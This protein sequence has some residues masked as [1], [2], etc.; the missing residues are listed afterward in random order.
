MNAAFSAQ[1]FSFPVVSRPPHT[2]THLPPSSPI[3]TH[4]PPSSPIF[5]HL[6][7]S[8]PISS[9]IYPQ[10]GLELPPTN[11]PPPLPL[12]PSPGACTGP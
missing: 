4:L 3:F 5:T 7:P 6:H 10:P 11:F 1:P 12:P 2:S 8:S 9:P